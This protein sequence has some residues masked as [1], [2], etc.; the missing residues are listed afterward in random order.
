MAATLSKLRSPVAVQAALDEYVRL[1]R[2]AFLA[3]YGFG[4][5][6][7][8]LVRDSFTGQLCD[9]KAIVGAA[10]G[11][12][13]PALGPLKNT[14]FSGGE[15]TVVLKLRQL[16]FEVVR[17]GEDW[18]R[19]EVDATVAAYF[20]ML[21]LEAQQIPYK[22]TEFNAELRQSLRGRSKAS[23]E[24]KFQNI[25]S[26]LLSMDL[27]F[28]AG[29][30]P[31]SNAQLLLRKA[32]QK[33][34]LDH[35]DVVGRIVDSLEEVKTPKEKTFKAIVVAPPSIE[36]LPLAELTAP[37]VRLPRKVD[38]AA[39]DE[40]NRRLGR[41]GEQWVIEFE[42]RRL[43]DAGMAELL[44]RVDWVSDRLGDGTG[45]D[46]LSYDRPDRERFIEVKT[47]NGPIRSSFIIS[48]NELDFSH[49]AAD[50]Y[51]LYRL[52]QF[53][54]SPKL[55]VLRGDLT[56]QL[57]LEPIDYRASFRRMML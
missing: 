42:H 55:Y 8:F 57:H 46:I 13:H 38:F 48:R 44:Q 9:S 11:H 26:V 29:Y 52:F 19:D 15:E 41:A 12:E 27:P 49:E 18:S 32:V 50:S 39:R 37:K 7:D 31:R 43:Q 10:Y 14:E 47:T 25:S 51:Y 16:G 24:L 23:V 5:S 20:E 45:F 22:K 28:V 34:A 30:K 17:V 53:R 2:T 6:R 3:R 40:S 56:T 1:G 36:D 54:E 33:F 35:P 21:R 4:K